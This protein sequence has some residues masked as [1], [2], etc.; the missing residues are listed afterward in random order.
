MR[1]DPTACRAEAGRRSL[2]REAFAALDAFDPLLWL[3][4]L[5]PSLPSRFGPTT[6]RTVKGRNPRREFPTG[7]ATEIEL[8]ALLAGFLVEEVGIPRLAID[9][10]AVAHG[11]L[12][13]GGT[14]VASLA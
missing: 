9:R 7:A 4:R 1:R 2:R 10:G 11:S 6:H 13:G 14:I 5:G 3:A 12:G 8:P